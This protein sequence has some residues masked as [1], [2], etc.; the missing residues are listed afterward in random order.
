MPKT[1]DARFPLPD[2]SITQSGVVDLLSGVVRQRPLSGEEALAELNRIAELAKEGN[3][4]ARCRYAQHLLH[5]PD[6]S[7]SNRRVLALLRPAA[8]AG[9]VEGLYLLGLITLR[10][11]GLAQN[12]EEGA[13]LVERAA[14]QGHR[15]AQKLL[16]DLYDHGWGREEN[17]AKALY[18]YRLAGAA[19][20]AVSARLAGLAYLKGR[21]AEVDTQFGQYWLEK[22]AQ[23]GDSIAQFELSRL[24]KRPNQSPDDQQL[25]QYW[26]KE[27]ALTGTLEA[28]FRLGLQYWSGQGQGVNL[29]E[30][31]RW[32][33]RAAE[34]GNLLAI[35]T[36]AGF[37]LAGN[38]LPINRFNAY[39]LALYA[40]R[41][42]NSTA[43]ITRQSLEALLTYRQKR[44]AVHFLKTTPNAKALI[45]ALI[46]RESR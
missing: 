10:G 6:E 34:G 18:W 3:L 14:G 32:T 13:T 16:A 35:A 38:I 8:A 5:N 22:A 21:G 23:L 20:D 17:P 25:G 46:P 9:H 40:E 24:L 30:S 33:C 11:Q 28:Q 26:L 4:D 19:G 42:G 37:F 44:E 27:S 2:E 39:V 29:Q 45:E 1:P 43:A 31:L 15:A 7:H 36:L 41:G 12:L